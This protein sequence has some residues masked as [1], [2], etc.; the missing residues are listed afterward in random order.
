MNIAPVS[1]VIPCYRCH[2]TLA[3]AVE[4]IL[5]QTNLPAEVILVEDCSEDDELTYQTMVSL[6]AAHP[7]INLRLEVLK[8]NI[9]PGGARNVGWELATQ[10]FIAFLDADDSWHPKKIEIQ[11]GW[12]HDHPEVDLSGHLSSQWGKRTSIESR[13]AVLA[14]QVSPRRLLIKN[15]FP[16]RSVMLKRNL[17]ERFVSGKRQAEDYLL[18]LTL[19]LNGRSLWLLNEALSYSYKYDYGEGGLNGLMKESYEGVLD[20]YYQLCR[21]KYISSIAYF[22]LISLAYFKYWRRMMVVKFNREKI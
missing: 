14:C 21:D 6:K 12:M 16:T 7:E 10:P 13:H 20:T 8:K 15:H 1:V 3:R 5:L 4:S 18:W 22:L 2:T 11:Y 9:G 17:S 19:S